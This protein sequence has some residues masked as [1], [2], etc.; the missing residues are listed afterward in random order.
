MRRCAFAEMTMQ[1]SRAR[2]RQPSPSVVSGSNG[3]VSMRIDALMLLAM[4]AACGNGVRHG[5]CICDAPPGDLDANYACNPLAQTGC[6]IG[7]KCTWIVDQLQPQEVGHVGCA[8]DGS[9][10]S[11]GACIPGPPGP[12]GFDDCVKGNICL[13]GECKVICDP[14]AAPVASGCDAQHF[15]QRYPGVFESGGMTIAGGCDPICDPLT[16]VSHVG[17]LNACASPDPRSPTSGCYTTNFETFGCMPIDAPTLA[18]RD[19]A[20]APTSLAGAPFVNGC[21]PGYIPLLLE[22]TGSMRVLCT[23]LCA[24]GEIDNGSQAHVAN[25]LG[26]DAPAKLVTAAAPAAG[27]GKCTSTK[28]GSSGAGPQNCVFVW[29]FLADAS[30]NPAPSQYNETLG[31]CRSF[32]QFKYDSD[33]NGQPDTVF[34]D[35]KDLP[36]RS[37]ATP[38]IAD[39][40]GDFGCQL[41]A[42]SQFTAAPLMKDFRLA[43]GPGEAVAH[44]LK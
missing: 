27:D 10:S 22:S 37:A 28:K 2:H 4:L 32:Q 21:A 24:P 38:G 35:C 39:D 12:D 26:T 8:P 29:S 30:G 25:A 34:P 23:G 16:Q 1:P 15:C 11:D 42:N 14:Q 31:V 9:A 3:H 17:N 44:V 33:N 6:L 36:P 13:G 20:V 7:E 43:Y 18:R 5:V 40:A 19:R 41:I